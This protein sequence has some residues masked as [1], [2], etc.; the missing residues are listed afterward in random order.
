MAAEKYDKDGCTPR[1][2][3]GHER[4]VCAHLRSHTPSAQIGQIELIVLC[5]TD[6]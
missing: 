6:V 3:A 4:D 5:Q 1:G 2:L